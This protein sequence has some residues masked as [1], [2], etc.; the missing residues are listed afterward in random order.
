MTRKQLLAFNLIHATTTDKV[1]NAE[2]ALTELY[3]IQEQ[4]IN[5]R[6]GIKRQIRY[7]N[8]LKNKRQ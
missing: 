4:G 1:L 3:D 7:I 5:V 6:K 8:Y 2:Q